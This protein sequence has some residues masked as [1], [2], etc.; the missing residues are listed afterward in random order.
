[1]QFEKGKSGNPGGRPKGTAEVRELARGL[2]PD[3]IRGLAKIA[4][5]SKAPPAARVAA[6]NALLDR[7]FGKAPQA[8]TG[9]DGQGP[10]ELA[11]R[12]LGQQR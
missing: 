5:D 8:L 10:V 11:V 1:M 9:E 7:G 3:A 6:W 2:G 12:W 4:K